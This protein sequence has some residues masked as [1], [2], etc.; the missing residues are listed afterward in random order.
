M[1]LPKEF[2]IKEYTESLQL[3]EDLRAKVEEGE[4]MSILAVS[5]MSDGSMGGWSTSTQ[6]IFAISGYM[7]AWAMLRMGFIRDEALLK[8]ED[9]E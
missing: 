8:K 1:S 7:L 6:N 5:E 2:Q 3:L 9:D 4:V